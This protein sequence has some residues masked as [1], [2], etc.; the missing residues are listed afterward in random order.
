MTS[1]WICS[2]CDNNLENQLHMTCGMC[3]NTICRKCCEYD[4]LNGRDA[5]KLICIDCLF[6]HFDTFTFD[7]FLKGEGTFHRGLFDHINKFFINT[8]NYEYE[9]INEQVK[10]K[11]KQLYLA[12]LDNNQ[13]DEEDDEEDDDDDD[14]N[15]NEVTVSFSDDDSDDD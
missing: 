1:P 6:D 15:D 13:N 9:N 7:I 5:D 4:K 14:H 11:L 10:E 12:R 8:M 2:N 3:K